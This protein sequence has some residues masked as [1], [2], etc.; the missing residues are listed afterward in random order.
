MDISETLK[1]GEFDGTLDLIIP[2]PVFDVSADWVPL[3]TSG[4][5]RGDIYLEM[6]FYAHGPAKHN[7]ALS[8]PDTGLSRRPSKLN[9]AER[10]WR[11]APYT[12]PRT[13]PS[14]SPSHSPGPYGFSVP[15]YFPS[16]SNYLAPPP[17]SPPSSRGSSSSPSPHGRARP[18]PGRPN[19]SVSPAIPTTLTPGAGV[20]RRNLSQPNSPPEQFALPP[21]SFP[22]SRASASSSP[23]RRASPLPPI[24]NE[25]P[26][27]R[28][29]LPNTLIPGT[30]APRQ[31]TPSQATPPELPAAL[32]PGKSNTSR[33]Q[34][35]SYEPSSQVRTPPELPAALR[36]GKSTTPRS[37]SPSYG[38]P[39]QPQ[40][41]HTANIPI[42]PPSR[43]P[44]P[45][46]FSLPMPGA[47]PYTDEYPPLS[48]PVP[49]P[50]TSY[51]N[52]R[53]DDTLVSQRPYA[54]L[55]R[56]A[57]PQDPYH[58]TRYSTPL[59]LPESL[60]RGRPL[61]NPNVEARRQELLRAEEEAAKRKQQEE[62]DLELARQLDREL[63]LE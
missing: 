17:A 1:T 14:S 61:S 48:F 29:S 55:G 58:L 2:F 32:R 50:V 39:P 10:L 28:P 46:Y 56:E 53:Y 11:P 43:S 31:R 54:N 6:T 49:A 63:N 35:P 33:T 8:V 20:H 45:T 16:Q 37:Q 59:P 3:E 15:D 23:Q 19:D 30:G 36:P 52:S 60:P 13:S 42:P 38:Y 51:T 47:Y 41:H 57:D 4:G 7:T 26:S 22:S 27:V 24:P 9:P 18:L 40:A 62:R 12:P 25:Q 5:S 44:N 34:S 21:A